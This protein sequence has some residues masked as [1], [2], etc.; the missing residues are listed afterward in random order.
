MAKAACLGIA[1]PL[2][3]INAMDRPRTR[4]RTGCEVSV[5]DRIRSRTEGDQMASRW[6]EL[7]VEYDYLGTHEGRTQFITDRTG[8]SDECI[9]RVLGPLMTQPLAGDEWDLEA[10]ARKAG[11][12]F[13][14]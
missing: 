7:M 3:R 5:A 12:S 14:E 11:V 9:R 1:K 13:E 2:A 4:K 10:Q 6:D 8:L